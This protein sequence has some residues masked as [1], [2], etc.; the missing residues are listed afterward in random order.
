MTAAERAAEV[1]KSPIGLVIVLAVAIGLAFLGKGGIVAAIVLVTA[2]LG[3][4]LFVLIGVVTVACYMLYAGR[5]EPTEFLNLIERI[6]TLADQPT[7]LAVPFFIMSGAVMSQGQ[8]SV[9]LI[10]FARACVGW[11]PGGLPMSAV[12]ACVFFAAIS[13]SSPATVVAIGAMMGPTLLQRGYSEKFAHGL[14]TSAGSLGILIPP[15]IPMILYPIVYQ[16]SFIEVERLFMAGYGPGIVIATVLMGFCFFYGV[17]QQMATKGKDALGRALLNG[18]LFFGGVAVVVIDFTN[19]PGETLIKLVVYLAVLQKIT[20]FEL[21][22]VGRA[23]VDGFWALLFPIGIYVGIQTGLFNAIEAAALSVVYAVVVEVYVHRAMKL[24]AVPKIFQETGV[25][26]GSLL[27]IMVAALAFSEFLE[28]QQIPA[29]MVAWIANMDLEPWQFLLI[30]N[31]LLLVVGMVMDILSAMFVF[32]PL[33]A[34][35]ATS[36]GVDPLH[37]GIIFIVNLEIGY[38]TPPV[39][40][41][42]FVASTLFERPLGHVIKSVLPFIALM[43]VGLMI[44]TYVPALSVGLANRLMDGDS[45]AAAPPPPN[46]GALGDDPDEDVPDQPDGVQSLEEMMREM[47]GGEGSSSSM[48]GVQSLEEM[49]RELEGAG[50]GAG[51]DGDDDGDDA[52]PTE[53]PSAMAPDIAPT[54]RVLTMEEMMEAAGVE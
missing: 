50:E 3:A 28:E 51:D 11:V 22:V 38:L 47:E 35:I 36:L 45:P 5:S 31:A 12:L 27:I 7:L 32:V 53:E 15:S 8:I 16:G 46:G 54:G 40:L 44:I 48:G 18:L 42:L 4:P 9:R 19:L 29:E 1:R 37:F 23:L 14:L 20:E 21:K 25:F 30:L 43:F 49:M 17:K 13:G 52:P 41:N 33:L 6:R 10:D 39:G 34:P 24:S 2:L 26:L